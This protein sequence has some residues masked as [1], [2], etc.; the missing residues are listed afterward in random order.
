MH[1]FRHCFSRAKLFIVVGADGPN[2]TITAGVH[3]Y[4]FSFD[5]PEGDLPSSYEGKYGAIRYWVQLQV[6]RPVARFSVDRHKAI[7]V[8]D[9]ININTP[10]LNVRIKIF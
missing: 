8:L 1:T 6:E 4:Q 7:T 5:L 3:Q 2:P 10:E 9:N